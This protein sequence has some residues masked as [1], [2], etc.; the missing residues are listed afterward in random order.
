MIPNPESTMFCLH[1]HHAGLDETFKVCRAPDRCPACG[2]ERV[3]YWL[4]HGKEGEDAA[5]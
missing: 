1:C 5:Q 4:E 3:E 2:S